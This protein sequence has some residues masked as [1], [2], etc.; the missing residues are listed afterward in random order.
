MDFESKLI[1]AYVE[2]RYKQLIVDAKLKDG[3]VAQALCADS[4]NFKNFYTKDTEIWIS[5][6]ND[7][8]RLVKY[9]CQLLN[10]G[11]GLVL[12]NPKYCQT[13]FEEAFN[14]GVLQDFSKYT[15]IRAIEHDDK[16]R[17]FDFELYNEDAEKC[18]VH[19]VKVIYKEGAYA[20]FPTFLDFFEMEVFEEATKLRKKGHKTVLFIIVPRM[21][22]LEAKFSWNINPVSAAKVFDEAKNGLEFICYSCNINQKSVTIA[23][24]MKINY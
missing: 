8:L 3:S 1:K 7:E 6:I 24:K 22:C 2:K 15:N 16:L 21:D 19:V 4:T 13:L 18:Y 10:R 20:I 14:N 5:K 9:E 12:V 23:N 17:H 11:D